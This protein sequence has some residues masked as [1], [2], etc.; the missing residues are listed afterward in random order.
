MDRYQTAL[1]SEIASQRERLAKLNE[2][3]ASLIVRREA[4]EDALAVYEETKS[5]H[6]VEQ[7]NPVEEQSNPVEC[8]GSKTASILNVIRES[9]GRGL[10]TSEIYEKTI[11]SDIRQPTVRNVLYNRK[12]DGVLEHLPNG[13]YRFP[14]KSGDA[15]SDQATPPATFENRTDHPVHPVE[16][17]AK[18]REAGTGGGT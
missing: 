18:G 11:G 1:H 8:A 3:I 13:R 9:G 16:P 4:F 14:Q 7:S 12:K 17:H 15:S 5:V 2:E 10:T 6:P